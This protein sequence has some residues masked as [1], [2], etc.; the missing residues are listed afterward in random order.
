MEDPDQIFLI[1]LI[2]KFYKS[3]LKMTLVRY[4]PPLIVLWWWLLLLVVVVSRLW[5]FWQNSV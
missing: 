3:I 5:F 2:L 4:L 1:D